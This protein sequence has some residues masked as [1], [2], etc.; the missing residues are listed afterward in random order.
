[1]G[2]NRGGERVSFRLGSFSASPENGPMAQSRYHW[3]KKMT[4]N[5]ELKPISLATLAGGAA[6]EAVNE[7]LERVWK[8]ICD[9]N[10]PPKVKRE[11]TLKLI[12]EPDEERQ[13]ITIGISVDKKLAKPRASVARVELAHGAG[14]KIIAVE[15]MSRQLPLDGVD[16][17]VVDLAS[18]REE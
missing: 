18:R 3:R 8:D 7:E 14:G 17:D 2:C 4:T 15:I 10:V 11:V 16:A 5:E 6:I 1:M 12:F 13:F 9:P